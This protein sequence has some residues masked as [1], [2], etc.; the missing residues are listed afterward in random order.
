MKSKV[1]YLLSLLL[2][3]PVLVYADTTA[4]ENPLGTNVG[5]IEI[6]AR[7]V[8]VLSGFTGVLGLV[9]FVFGGF[10]ILT[11]AGNQDKF[12]KGKTI[13]MYSGLGMVVATSSY[14]I[15]ITLI[16]VL[17][18]GQNTGLTTAAG[19]VDP[20]HFNVADPSA[21]VK[22]YG[23]RLLGFLLSGLG[24]LTLLVFVYAGLLWMTAAGNEE[25]IAK[26]RQTILYGVL[27][28]AAVLGSYVILNFIITPFYTLLKSGEAPATVQ[29]GYP[30]DVPVDPT[31]INGGCWASGF[32]EENNLAFCTS[33]GGTF[34]QGETCSDYGCCAQTK[35]TENKSRD[36]QEQDRVK[37][38][39]CTQKFFPSYDKPVPFWGCL[40][41][42][43]EEGG[44][45]YSPVIFIQGFD[46]GIAHSLYPGV[47][48]EP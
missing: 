22:F 31:T 17:T 15:L 46:C 34:F 7:V 23:G 11:A 1:K 41:D 19:L 36:P 29:E 4:L 26:A 25:K 14:F 20:L 2:L 18:Q 30:V 38:S 37:A 42:L 9:F 27:G 6:F 48:P 21:G 33:V 12:A 39:K 8:W 35:K 10:R 24:A 28:L 16:N 40:G 45:C 3:L 32:C 44:L 13:L 43:L 47:F 5:V